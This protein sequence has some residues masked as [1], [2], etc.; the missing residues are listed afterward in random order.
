MDLS[1]QHSERTSHLQ[2]K[3]DYLKEEINEQRVLVNE[4]K[5]KEKE[6]LEMITEVKTS[7][8]LF[9]FLSLLIIHNT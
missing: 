3:I 2:A 8:K 1:R 5:T 9:F 6:R 7:V 4:Q